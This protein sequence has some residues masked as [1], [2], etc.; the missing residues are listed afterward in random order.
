MEGCHSG[1]V[2]ADTEVLVDGHV[3][4]LGLDHYDDF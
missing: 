3:A 1:N 4:V 2:C